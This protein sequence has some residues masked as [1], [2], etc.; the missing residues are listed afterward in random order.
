MKENN[1]PGFLRVVLMQG[2]V[3]TLFQ[4]GEDQNQVVVNF[5]RLCRS[6]EFFNAGGFFLWDLEHI[7][8]SIDDGHPLMGEFPVSIDKLK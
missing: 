3:L 5:S 7:C 4:A 2:Y 6:N 1:I 8:N